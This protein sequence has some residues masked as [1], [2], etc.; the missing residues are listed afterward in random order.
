MNRTRPWWSVANVE[1]RT[2]I[3]SAIGGEPGYL[4]RDARFAEL[5]VEL[6]DFEL[7]VHDLRASAWQ[8]FGRSGPGALW[9]S[10]R[11]TV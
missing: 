7:H 9:T 3:R 6:A 5:G 11:V 2:V 8:P 1:R 4:M 10:I